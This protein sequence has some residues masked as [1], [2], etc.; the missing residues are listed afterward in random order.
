MNR[1]SFIKNTGIA[2]GMMVLPR[3][4]LGDASTQLAANNRLKLALVGVGGRGA[5]ALLGLAKEDFVALCDVD[6]TRVAESRQSRTTG[7][8]FSAA[9][10][11]VEAKGAKWYR[12]YRVMF[13]EMEDKIDAVAS[14]LNFQFSIFNSQFSIH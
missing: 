5:S 13:E 10:D 8:A 11:Q 9:L 4:A 2:A 7:E 12:D 3:F 6:D 1:R 14:I